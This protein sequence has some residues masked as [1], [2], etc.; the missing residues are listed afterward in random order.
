MNHFWW[1]LKGGMGPYLTPMGR[2]LPR[3]L[4]T[5]VTPNGLK[6]I[7]F[8]FMYSSQN[9]S[10]LYPAKGLYQKKVFKGFFTAKPLSLVTYLCLLGSMGAYVTS[11]F[12]RCTSFF[13]TGRLG[14]H[15]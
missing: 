2:I 6:F 11:V 1:R 8:T 4:K 13:P 7:Y 15:I 10:E 3:N 5:F 12:C 9:F 14:S